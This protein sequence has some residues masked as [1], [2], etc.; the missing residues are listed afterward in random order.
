MPPCECTG[1]MLVEYS[2]AHNWSCETRRSVHATLKSFFRWYH[3][4]GYIDKDISIDLPKV[5][6]ATP[7]PRPASDSA[8]KAGIESGG[9]RE[10]FI[11]S[12]AA[13]VG[14]RREEIVKV[15]SIDI[16]EDILGHS[17]RVHGK[18]NKERVVPLPD[19][20]ARQIIAECRRNEGYLLPGN[21]EG[22]MSARYAGKLATRCLPDGITL[23]MLRHRF[24]TVAYNRSRDIVAVQDI[25]GHTNPATTRRYIAIEN[26]RLREVIKLAG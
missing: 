17:L 5:K 1:K 16:N 15:H 22:H 8:V 24:G 20:L 3:G 12:L 23:H 4:A 18:G 14:L 7:R 21:I 13:Y 25:L 2:S 10:Y 26:S 9:Y 6:P 11:L 19:L